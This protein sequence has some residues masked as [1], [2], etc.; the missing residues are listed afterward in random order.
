LSLE[1][2]LLFSRRYANVDDDISRASCR[3]LFFDELI[4]WEFEETVAAG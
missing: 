1:I 4:V 3:D 2:V